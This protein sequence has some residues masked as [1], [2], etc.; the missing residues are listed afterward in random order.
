MATERVARISCDGCPKVVEFALTTMADT[1]P[2]ARAL[3]KGWVT[4]SVT[5]SNGQYKIGDFH[6]RVCAADW[7][8][9]RDRT[10]KPVTTKEAP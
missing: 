3:P 9:K 4:V 10:R 7:V 8:Q 5:G 6:S 1:M 2:E